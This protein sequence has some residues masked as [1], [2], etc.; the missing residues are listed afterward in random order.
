M[1]YGAGPAGQ[2]GRPSTWSGGAVTRTTPRAGCGTS[3]KKP[4]AARWGWATTSRGA[5]TGAQGMRAAVSASRAASADVKRPSHSAIT[6]RGGSWG[7][8]ALGGGERGGG[9]GAGGG[10]RLGGGVGGR[11][12]PEPLRDHR[13]EGVLVVA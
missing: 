4:R 3:G 6:A 1:R 12:A 2:V 11:E 8:R 9:G 5:S 13:A 10:G 7:A